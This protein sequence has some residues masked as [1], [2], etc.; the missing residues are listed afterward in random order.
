[1]RRPPSGRAS[2]ARGEAHL[3]VVGGAVE[4]G[5]SR[6]RWGTRPR[7]VTRP[8][9][10]TSPVPRLD[11]EQPLGR[12]EEV[13]RVV[14]RVEPGDVGAEDAAQQGRATTR[15]AGC[16]T[17]RRPGTGTWRKNAIGR[18]GARSRS[19]RG[20]QHEVVVVHPD[21]VARLARLEH[22]VAEALVHADVGGP[23][24]A[25]RGA[26]G[27][28]SSAPAA[29]ASGCR[30]PRRSARHVLRARGTRATRAS[31]APPRHGCAG[32]RPRP[33]RRP[34]TRPTRAAPPVGRGPR[35]Q[36]PLHPAHQPADRPR[37]PRLPSVRSTANGS[38]FETTTSRPPAGAGGSFA[39]SR[40]L[41]V[42]RV[43]SMVCSDRSAS[44][45]RGA[46]RGRRHGPPRP[47]RGPESRPAGF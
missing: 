9:R 34:A 18:S 27:T 46:R 15:P 10:R 36:V 21:R 41:L 38:R 28:G 33:A 35:P 26:R 5:R 16:G 19:S 42:A 12:A 39:D 37:E 31:A 25:P 1:M 24:G 32:A 4:A 20:Q 14:V 22:R 45:D 40:P 30:S 13:A 43:V 7:S 44:R 8:P 29:R 17:P 3:G 23:V 6:R 47:T 2:A 11:A